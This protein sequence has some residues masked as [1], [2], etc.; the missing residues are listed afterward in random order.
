M[1]S[2]STQ[3]IRKVKLS[4]ISS[5]AVIDLSN[6]KI[7]FSIQNADVEVPDNIVIRV[8]NLSQTTI[9]QI[10]N[11]DKGNLQTL[12]EFNRVI[13]EAGYEGSGANYGIIFDGS[14][15][16][17]R[18]GRENNINSYIDILASDG[19]LGYSQTFINENIKAGETQ[20]QA[21]QRISNEMNVKNGTGPS[22]I[23][24]QLTGWSPAY[25]PVI[26]GQVL[27]GM[28]R[29]RMRMYSRSLGCSWS[30]QEGKVVITPLTQ[31]VP[32]EIV[33]INS[34]TGMIGIPEQTDGGIRVRTLLNSKIKIGQLVELNNAD[35]NQTVN[36]VSNP[37]N[38][39]Y[40]SR[41]VRQNLAPLSKS[42]TY[43]AFVVEHVGDTRGDEWYTD[44][45]CLGVDLTTGKVPGV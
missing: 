26:R 29:A 22:D 10:E 42:G 31:Y 39:L 40:N 18:I 38:I 35:I 1:S 15:K 7:K 32:G 44:L 27:F 41:S 13:L 19:D 34:A 33:K 21:I 43:R 12:G 4:I 23:L 3:W 25:T 14:I 30:I 37:T 8:Y 28:G 6:L 2:L 11:T 5:K 20:I 17:M 36:A 24:T 9:N 16:Q 45:I